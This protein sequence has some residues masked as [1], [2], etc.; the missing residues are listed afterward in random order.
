MLFG[1]MAVAL[2]VGVLM[3]RSVV[4]L[5]CDGSLP[6]WML[7]AQGYRGGGCAQVLPTSEAPEGA[8]WSRYCLGACLDVSSQEPLEARPSR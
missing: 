6:R 8:D 7:E 2:L 4:H 1:A 5:E 3:N